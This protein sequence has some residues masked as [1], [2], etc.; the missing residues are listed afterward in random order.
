MAK[1]KRTSAGK[2]PAGKGGARGASRRTT[3]PSAKSARKGGAPKRGSGEAEGT[4][5]K[6]SWSVVTYEELE[7]WRERESLPK[8]R[9]AELIG[10]TNSTYHNWARGLAVATPNTQRKIRELIDG[11]GVSIGAAGASNGL[12]EESLRTTAQ[13]VTTYLQT[14]HQDGMDPENLTKLVREVRQALLLP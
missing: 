3:K 1:K 14:Q 8:K 4:R 7:A 5:R 12:Q 13:I 2:S 9:A 10:V 11:E 6:R